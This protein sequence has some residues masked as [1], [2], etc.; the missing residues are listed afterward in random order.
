MRSAPKQ[1]GEAH[2]EQRTEY[3]SPEEPTR[4]TA[5]SPILTLGVLKLLR[6][7]WEEPAEMK[8]SLFWG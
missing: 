7:G 5:D 3:P 8:E 2:R 1:R 4:S 6:K